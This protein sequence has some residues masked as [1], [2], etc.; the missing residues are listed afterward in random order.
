[1]SVAG[2]ES[3]AAAISVVHIALVKEFKTSREDP[4]FALLYVGVWTLIE[5]NIAIIFASLPPCL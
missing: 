5:L 3:L 1:M 2:L 4:T